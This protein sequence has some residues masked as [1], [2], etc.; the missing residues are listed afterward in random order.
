MTSQED[1]RN[2]VLRA[3]VTLRAVQIALRQTEPGTAQHRRLL[4]AQAQIED[5]FDLALEEV[6]DL[7]V[8]P[9]AND[10]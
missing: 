5:Q 6:G 7:I 1:A 4:V 8:D 9:I 10:D 2:I 3:A